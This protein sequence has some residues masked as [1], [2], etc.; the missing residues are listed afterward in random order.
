MPSVFHERATDLAVH[1][2]ILST[3]LY[4]KAENNL[5]RDALFIICHDAVCTHRAI[6]TLVDFGWSGPGAA[7]LR[8]LL[9][10]VIST[11]AIVNSSDPKMAAFRYMY[12]GFRRHS[13]DPSFSAQ[14][15]KAMFSQIRHRISLL[16]NELKSR[17]LAVVKERDRPY[18]FSEEFRSPTEILEKHGSPGMVWA[19]LQLSAAAHGTMMGLRLFRDDPDRIDVN[20]IPPGPKSYS[21]D[22]SSSRFLISVVDLRNLYEHLGMDSAIKAFNNDLRAAAL[23]SSSPL[24]IQISLSN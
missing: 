5:V 7:V 9:D 18:W 10:L 2:Q 23:G 22:L 14:Q 3:T 19:Y 1:A 12:S 13:R 4:A 20:P 8:A 16:P 6:G 17:A 11:A 15:R 21:L 24:P